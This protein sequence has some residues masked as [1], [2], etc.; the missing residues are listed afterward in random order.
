METIKTDVLIVGTGASGLFAALHVPKDK[1]VLMI[2]K[3][4]M[5]KS[6]SFLAQGG[7]CVLRNDD[8]YDSFFEDTMKAGHYENRKES[9]DIMIRSSRSIIEELVACGVEFTRKN[10]EFDYTREGCHSKPRILYHEDI[11]GEEITSKLLARVLEKDN[12]KILEN[13]SMVDILEKENTCFGVLAK[14]ENLLSI[15]ANYTILATGGIGGLF[16]SSTNYRHLTA[17]ALAIAI[18][19]RVALEHPEYIQI[20]PTTLYSKKAGRSFLISE[21]VRGE[22]AKLYGADGKRFAD[23]ILPRDLLTKEIL[24]QMKKDQKPYV[25]LDMTVLGKEE[26][27]SHFPHIY[28]HCL[29]QGYD[30]TKEWIP[31]V[32]GQHYYMGGIHVDSHSKTTMEQLYAI[33]ET[34]C[35]GVHGKNRLA[36]NSLLESL[37]FAKRAIEHIKTQKYKTTDDFEELSKDAE[38]LLP[39]NY[40]KVYKELVLNEIKK[41]SD[42]KMN[43]ITMSMNIDTLILQALRE[44]ITSEDITTNAIM[45]DYQAGTVQLICKEDG[46]IAGLPV[47]ERVFHLTD[48]KTEVVF[49]F[50]DGDEVKNGDL[51]G[52]ITGDIRVLLSAERT[53]LNYLQRMSGIATYTHQ[54]SDMLKGSK[55]KLLDTRKTTPNMRVFEKYAVK[56]GGG[57][58]HRYNLSD[59]ILL[60]DN[61]IAAAGGITN[62]I[63]MAKEYASFVR[64]IEI[65]VE[66]MDMVKEAIEAGADIIMLD[67]MSVEQMKEAVEYING[68]ALTECS[69]NVTKENIE[70]LVAIGVDYISSGAL[71]HTAGILDLSLKNLKAI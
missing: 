65:E 66:N 30:C 67:N 24:K 45:K 10:G 54:V 21:S 32:P 70:K 35:N 4:K 49:F 71:T 62:A 43:S 22:G 27:I 46:V 41:R 64:K 39:E 40:E 37:V 34:S 38:N 36:S 8:D 16:T 25:W 60:K 51:V 48:P 58:N 2:T 53:A 31:V 3:S 14:K 57:Y 12:I 9:V 61:H 7:I 42:V 68:R 6:D 69:G 47:F 20:H 59:G 55:T 26:I 17:D 11:T 23:E 50:N 5:N 56:A 15:Q 52:E 19:H 1:N 13:T 33:G 63:N 29:E 44:D 18:R 28:E